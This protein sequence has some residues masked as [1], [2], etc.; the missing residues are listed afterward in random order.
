MNKK[1]SRSKSKNKK[2]MV[3]A[4][5]FG[6]FI[7]TFACCLSTS[8]VTGQTVLFRD[9]TSETGLKFNHFTGATG[10]F[11]MPEI[12]GS[13]CAL[14]DYDNDGDLDVYLVQS[15]LLNEK[16]KLEDALFPPAPNWKPGDRLFRNELIPTGKLR[17]TDVTVQAGIVSNGYGMG[18][19]T[20]DIDNDGDVDLYV[21]R[22]G[23]N[24]LYRNNGKGTFTEI[25][26]EA[27]VDD[28]R[29][30]TS[31]AFVDYD[32]D[33][34]LD[35]YVTNY[36]DFSV[37]GNKKCLAPTGETDY[38]TP[39]AYRPLL[40][41]LFRN[42]GKGRFT[43]VTQESGIGKSPGPG[44]GVSSADFNGDGLIDIYVA[45]DGAAN[46]LW[47]NKGDGTFEE[48]GL[49]A[50]V[51]YG[52]DGMAQA[53]MGVAAGDFDNDGDEDLLVTNLTR[54]GS[55]L[56]RNDG[57]GIFSDA[58]GESDLTRAT[59]LSTG[60]G[61]GWFDY[62][63]DGRLDLFAA[64]GAVTIIPALK[65]SKWPFNQH[66][67][68]F[69]NEPGKNGSPNFREVTAAAGAAFQLS[70]VSRGTALGDVDNDGDV[71]LLIANNNGPARLLLNEAGSRNHW[72]TVQLE[73]V[74]DNRNG[75]G[76]R[77]AVLLKGKQLI[78]RR[79]HTDG[80]YLSASDNR[81]HFGLGSA[82]EIEGVIVQWP[83]GDKELWE[84]AQVNKLMKLR[85]GT[86]KPWKP[87]IA[88]KP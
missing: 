23:S 77:V 72:L 28:P 47:V 62:D 3:K 45:N 17:F 26:A 60:F 52:A 18:V 9:A 53:G 38:C 63:N 87:S 51:A 36:V 73:G 27:G 70:E 41:R 79:A 15:S 29:W 55:T 30:S 76:A 12:M 78:W 39:A 59:F 5:I 22:F 2:R 35:L 1:I 49:F 66:N 75:I 10:D 82:T 37:K 19:A 24:S 85:Q 33:G 16:K 32:R 86:G 48:T 8:L 88:S 64:N 31:A 68:L 7:L 34:D 46:L 69:R 43:D 81:V 84:I 80:S 57:R 42:E 44:L 13:G 6:V 67:Q 74:K 21:T 14:F 56:Y 65:S 83:G 61:A 58:T 4:L 71:D 54:E 25:T 20:G 40:D 11:F 50:G